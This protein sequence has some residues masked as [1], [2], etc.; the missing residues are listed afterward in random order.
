MSATERR[1]ATR[2]AVIW[3]ALQPALAEAQDVLDIGGG[4][5]GLAVRV[6]EQGPRVRVVDPSPDALASLARRAAE[7]GVGDRVLAHQGDLSSLDAVVEAGSADLVL[8]HGVLDMVDD[9]AAA[10][11]QIRA[12]L[13]PGGHL[14]LVVAQRHA[15]VIA[16]AMAGHF[17]AA[18]ALLEGE[19]GAEPSGRGVRRRFTADEVT[20]LLAASGFTVQGVQGVRIFAD[21]VPGTVVDLEPG[22]TQALAELE[23]AVAHRPEYRTLATQIHLIATC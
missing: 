23:H 4:T 3:E 16:R 18:K 1:S 17:V 19:S 13:R 8:C 12:T 22:A 11:A 21:L 6:A 14:S 2:T 9:P 15:A 20:E 7:S 5:G 10:I